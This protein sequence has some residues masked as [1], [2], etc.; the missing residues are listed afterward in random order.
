MIGIYTRVSTEDQVRHG[1]SLAD[2]LRQCKDLAGTEQHREYTDEGI[3]GAVLRR[4]ALAKLLNDVK[5]GIIT[6]VICYHTDRL[7]RDLY[8]LGYI[9]KKLEEKKVQIEFVNGKYEQTPEGRFGFQIQ[10]AVAELEKE[11]IKERMMRGRKQKALQGLIVKDPKTFGYGFNKTTRQLEINEEEAEV[12]KLIFDMFGSSRVQGINGVANY[13]NEMGIPTKMKKGVWHRQVVRQM[14]LNETYT[15]KFYQNKWNCEGHL[16]NKYK[17]KDEHIAITKRPKEDQI[18]VTVPVIIEESTFNHVQSLMEEVRRR[19]AGAPKNEYLLSGLV[20][21]GKC[22]NTFTGRKS[23]NWGTEAFEYSDVK[24]TAGAKNPGCGKRIKMTELDE[25]VWDKVHGWLNNSGAVAEESEAN[26]GDNVS[27]EQEEIKRINQRI[28]DIKKGR[29]KLITLLM[30]NVISQEVAEEK[31]L[32]SNSE[33][34]NLIEQLAKLQEKLLAQQDHQLHENI[35]EEAVN[36]LLSKN[37]DLDFNDR[38]HIIRTLV[39]EIRVFDDEVKIFG[40]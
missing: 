28:V 3:S 14:L 32:E 17:N 37:G 5:L 13:L 23:K 25:L 18:L 31:I 30:N 6:K 8:N 2:Q 12:V 22:G 27:Y 34:N 21:C 35:L 39:R 36:F 7:S 9:M 1:Y 19:H 16:Y 10:G 38:K 15:G 20:R 26:G 33:E 29:D 11:Q 4:P 24:N 40:W